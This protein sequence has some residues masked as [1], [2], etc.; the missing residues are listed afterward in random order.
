MQ[1]KQ[2]ACALY[3]NEEKQEQAIA[4]R[5]SDSTAKIFSL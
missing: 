3:N 4:Q 1:Q 2:K 5:K